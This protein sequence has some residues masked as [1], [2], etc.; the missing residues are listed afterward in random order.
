MFICLVEENIFLS[1]DIESTGMQLNQFIM[2]FENS[3]FR[4]ICLAFP[5]GFTGSEVDKKF[6][7]SIGKSSPADISGAVVP[8]PSFNGDT[9]AEPLPAE[10]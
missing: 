8:A 4:D 1:I 6:P 7:L 5:I 2:K 3:R 9:L 10:L